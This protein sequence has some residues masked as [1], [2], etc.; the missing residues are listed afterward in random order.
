M[1]ARTVVLFILMSLASAVPATA[2]AQRGTVRGVLL[3]PAGQPAPRIELRVVNE[4]TGEVRRVIS[5]DEGRYVA[6]ELEPGT[7][8]IEVAGGKYREF[9]ARVHVAVRQ[10]Q[11]LDLPLALE[12]VSTSVDVR[13]MFL[14]VDRDTA[15]LTTRVDERIVTG[16]P[17]DGRNFLELALLAPGT[18]PAPQGSAASVRG[19]FAFPVNGAR[20]DFTSY[21]LDG[22]YNVDPKLGTP[23]VRP[24]VDAIR[25]FEVR[26]STY[27]ATFGR[28]G[29][30]QVNVVTR[31]GSNR[32]SGAAYEFYRNGAL[33]SRNY[34]AP[35]DEEAPE[36]SRH[37]FGG[38][39]GGPVVRDRTFFFA[40][41]EHTRLREGITRVTNVPTRA[42][43]EGDFSAS[44]FARPV[45]PGTSIPFAG[46]IIPAFFQDPRGRAIAAL[47]PE[48]NRSTPF[49]NFVSS[50]TLA[51]DIHQFDGRLDHVLGV[52]AHVTL[53]YSLNDRSLYE[54]FAGAGFSSLPGFGNDVARR[55]QNLLAAFTHV[56]KA[57]LVHDIR[58]G[59]NRVRI[60]VSPEASGITNT[61]VGLPSLSADPR[62]AGPA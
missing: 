18:A 25:E 40:D 59:Y 48:P 19:D 16:V 29:G 51:D 13:A 36:Y 39:M 38:A 21:L 49:A 28:N 61:G 24:P 47:F 6:A 22:V 52:G 7:Y 62:H 54:P 34:F 31:S 50:P 14:P 58:F 15:A 11:R 9:A 17:L 20:E 56:P 53:R 12:T 27:D 46:G 37:Q 45:I 32:L 1:R 8:R 26:T 10:D 3:D 57:T 30:G 44:L 43:R 55:G 5:D 23:G 35:R 60:D 4:A 41:Y 42:E 33:D 2:Q